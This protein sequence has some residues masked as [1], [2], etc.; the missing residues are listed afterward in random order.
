MT[1]CRQGVPT[2]GFDVYLYMAAI[3]VHRYGIHISF[4][5]IYDTKALGGKGSA[6]LLQSPVVYLFHS[7]ND[8]IDACRA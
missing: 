4:H 3:W 2:S 6:D 8:A 5:I 7:G 1:T